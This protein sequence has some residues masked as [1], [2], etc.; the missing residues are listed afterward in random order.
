MVHK[1]LAEAMLNRPAAAVAAATSAA[2]A[3]ALKAERAGSLGNVDRH[4]PY[5]VLGEEGRLA[6]V[7]AKDI[8]KRNCLVVCGY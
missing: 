3:A 2:A 1:R 6:Q 7:E 4:S 5:T 8:S